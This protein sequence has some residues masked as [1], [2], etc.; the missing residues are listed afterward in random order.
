MA[1]VLDSELRLVYCNPAWDRFAIQNQGAELKWDAVRWTPVLEAIAPPLRP[2]YERGFEAVAECGSVWEHD[3]ECSSARLFRRY[4]MQVKRLEGTGG[5]LVVNSL[6]VEES[7]PDV[8]AVPEGGLDVY[9]G[10]DGI[11]TMCCHCRRTR[12]A[13]GSDAWDWVPHHLE[14]PPEPVSHGLC[15]SCV[16]YF[17]P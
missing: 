10:K 17:Y 16:A 14:R 6:V 15:S 4:H 8:G 7:H 13:H 11:V 1:Y 12:R 9:Q 3:F 5:F 2:F